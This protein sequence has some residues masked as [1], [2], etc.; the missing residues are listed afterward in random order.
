[1]SE[2]GCS[3]SA[4]AQLLSP[5]CLVCELKT[6]EGGGGV[7]EI[8]PHQ[9]T[10]RGPFPCRFLASSSGGS[11]HIKQKLN[12]KNKK[13]FPCEVIFN[14]TCTLFFNGPSLLVEA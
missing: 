14:V 8:Q 1:M 5:V 4:A 6:G 3:L 12:K 10:D 11:A 13:T 2:R 7:D 9:R